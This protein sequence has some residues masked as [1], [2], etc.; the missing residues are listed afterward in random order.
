MNPFEFAKPDYSDLI[1]KG[2][3]CVDMHLHSTYSDGAATV[4]QLLEKAERLGIG[5][6][7][8]DHNEIG[9]SLEAISKKKKKTIIIP[10]IEVKSDELIDV[11][12]YFYDA[13]TMKDFFQKEI[14]PNR[15]KFFHATKTTVSI[16]RLIELPKKYSCLMSIPHPYGY[17]MR[18]TLTDIFEKYEHILG[19]ADVFEAINGGNNRKQ[20]TKAIEYIESKG[21]SFTAGT[22]GHSIYPI[23]NI[24]T[25]S[26]ADNIKDFLDNIRTKSNFVIGTETRFRKFGEYFYF[27]KNK[28]R[29]L[30][31]NGP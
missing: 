20:N 28:I 9:G 29:N 2:S 7:I 3:A 5:L 24:L 30:L 27:G 4:G 1:K 17:S 16:N 23:G 31:Q 26:K 21:K 14:L 22:D 15:Q 12:Y 19:K 25:C 13:A 10:G 8:T 6:S 11:L 18:T